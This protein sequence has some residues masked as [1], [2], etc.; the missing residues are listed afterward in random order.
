M[1]YM[2]SYRDKNGAKSEICMEA[3]NRAECV[4]ACR[5]RGISPMGVREGSGGRAGVPASRNGEGI[6][7]VQKHSRNFLYFTLAIA[8]MAV[9][10]L[11]WWWF[12][13][14]PEPVPT[15]PAETK[16]KAVPKE[17]VPTQASSKPATVASLGTN[18]PQ[19]R[20]RKH[21]PKYDKNG[22]RV[23]KNPN[24]P[25][26]RS[27]RSRHGQ[28]PLVDF[29]EKED[30]N[31]PPPRYV[32]NLQLNL[33]EYAVPGRATSGV[34]PITDKEARELLK[35]KVVY[36]FDDSEA[37]LAEKKAVEELQEQLREWMDGG[38][39]AMKFMQMLEER[40]EKESAAMTEVQKNVM[41]FCKEGDSDAAK[42]ALDKYNVYLESQGMPKMKMTHRMKRMLEK[43]GGVTG[44]EIQSGVK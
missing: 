37:V 36:R 22:Q 20:V 10:A 39:H 16:R 29:R 5:A 12:S 17:V 34:D 38:G 27:W 2:V 19:E 32:N 35:Q 15:P 7:C 1:I 41:E 25:V 30:P 26:A 14:R 9:I 42:A 18:E 33:S 28:P 13:A 23:F 21:V 8:A 24:S 43:A 3:A 6:H 40:Q 4:A 11:V 44:G 31:A